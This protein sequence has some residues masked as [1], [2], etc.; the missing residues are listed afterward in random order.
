M[1]TMS[2][3][4]AAQTTKH[5]LR[6]RH[7]RAME[8]RLTEEAATDRLTGEIQKRREASVKACEGICLFVAHVWCKL[9]IHLHHEQ[10]SLPCAVQQY[11][12]VLI[13]PWVLCRS[14]AWSATMT[15]TKPCS[16]ISACHP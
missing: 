11:E 6:E 9:R 12:R 14:H 5:R 8:E 10:Q 13:G 3:A 15:L 2:A 1:T 16:P 7:R 4:R